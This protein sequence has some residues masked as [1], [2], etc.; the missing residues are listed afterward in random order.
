MYICVDID[1]TCVKHTKPLSTTE[2]V[3]H[4]AEVL[5]ELVNAGHKLIIFTMRSNKGGKMLLKDS[6]D[7]F[8]KNDIDLYASQKNPTQ[9]AWTNSPKAYGSVYIDDAALGCPLIKEEGDL[10]PYV[11]WLKVRELLIEQNVL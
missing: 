3:P 7:W 9:W 5:K 1:G 6:E 4:A 11:D 10:R 2:D 8:K